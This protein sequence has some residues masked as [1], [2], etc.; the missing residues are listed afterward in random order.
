MEIVIFTEGAKDQG[1]GHVV[2]CF[3]ICEALRDVGIVDSYLVDV[4]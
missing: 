1:L 3:A 4:V 2:R